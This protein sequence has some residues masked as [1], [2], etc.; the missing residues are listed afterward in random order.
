MSTEA[1]EAVE[2]RL[3]TLLLTR[4]GS[5]DSI[6]ER[7]A[8][9]HADGVGIAISVFASGT[10][11]ACRVSLQPPTPGSVKRLV[12]AVL[13]EVPAT[14]SGAVILLSTLDSPRT[15][16]IDRYRRHGLRLGEE[17]IVAVRHARPTVIL[18]H[19]PCFMSWSPARLLDALVQKHEARPLELVLLRTTTT[20]V[21][22][23]GALPCRDGLRPRRSP[24]RSPA[25]LED[26]IA[27]VA[28]YLTGQLTPRMTY[29]YD[30]WRDR[31]VR[32][33]APGRVA[34]ALSALDAAGS[35]LAEP[36]LVERASSGL[37]W[38]ARSRP[39]SG[40]IHDAHF[41]LARPDADDPPR[42]ELVRRALRVT[43]AFAG[44]DQEYYPGVALA[45]LAARGALAEGEARA[46]LL[47]YRERF[48]A[49]PTWPF[50]WWQLRAWSTI[51]SRAMLGAEFAFE[52]ADWA[53]ERRLPGG[54][55]DIRTV[56]GR[57]TFQSV[58]VAEGLLAAA[59]LALS[60]G[61]RVRA[62]RYASGAR[63]A[64]RW[65]SGLVLDRSHAPLLP[66]GARAA[67]GVQT[68]HGELILRSDVAGHYLA[69]LVA[70]AEL[71]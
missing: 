24:L 13:A 16:S 70:L 51:A 37:E 58:C 23:D 1:I 71:V 35:F 27:L 5:V 69:A 41:L 56:P 55:F 18:A 19:V 46:S 42:V 32:S 47:H 50:V 60:A 22:D 7:L 10:Q 40:D 66:D 14:N 20:W 3:R 17:S 64:L 26:E 68:L 29:A 48:R 45:A 53:V 2:A 8:G 49:T 11:L 31:E 25:Q 54:A 59:G 62:Q 34:I 44:A 21:D 63:E 36:A 15:V 12:E 57:E 33:D 65:T 52:L 9:R 38:L 67:G 61:D 43:G 28:S 30:A 4:E 39:P 6:A